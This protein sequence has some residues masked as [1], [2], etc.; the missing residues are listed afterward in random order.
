[1]DFYWLLSTEVGRLLATIVLSVLYEELGMMKT[2]KCLLVAK[3]V[4]LESVGKNMKGIKFDIA[5]IQ[6]NK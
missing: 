1:M 2:D 6:D 5:R 3:F 4:R